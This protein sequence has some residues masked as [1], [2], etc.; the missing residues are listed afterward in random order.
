VTAAPGRLIGSGKEAEVFEYG[1]D[2]L[3]LYRSPSAKRSAFREAF[4]L[5]QAGALALPVPAAKGVLAIGA[6]WGIVM[7]RAEGPAWAEAMLKDEGAVAGYI[8]AM[9][10]LHRRIHE[11]S[12][13]GL[14]GLRA[15]LAA[16]IAAAPVLGA[17]R[18]KRL[19]AGLAAMPEGDRLC[20]GDF[21]PWNI[22]GAPS[23]PLVVDWLD[24]ASGDPA[25]DV[26]RSFVLI[27][28]VRPE[29]AAAYVD[30]YAAQ[31]AIARAAIM[32][33]LPFIAGARCAENIADE[34]PRLVAMVDSALL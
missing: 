31:L 17:E 34:V 16:R 2:V 28:S 6:R 25:A 33:W 19:L 24:A 12:G 30:A 13:A 29:M 32:A 5:A 10:A 20:H 1:S 14:E 27:D 26:C 8:A 18:Q 22:M 11:K 7:D 3:K 21:H 9:V 23:Q 4:I 15:R